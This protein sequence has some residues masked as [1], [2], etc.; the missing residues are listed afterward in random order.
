MDGDDVLTDAR[1]ALKQ[2]KAIKGANS[3][4]LAQDC[5]QRA[6]DAVERIVEVA[7]RSAAAPTE[8]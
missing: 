5:A 2:L 8:G 7:E 6:I 3:W 1:Y 4:L